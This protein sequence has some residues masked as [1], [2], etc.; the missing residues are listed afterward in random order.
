MRV[1]IVTVQQVNL[2]L[3]VMLNSSS[4]WW[5]LVSQTVLLQTTS[6]RLISCQCYLPIPFHFHLAL[7]SVVIPQSTS[8]EIPRQTG[9]LLMTLLH[10]FISLIPVPLLTTIFSKKHQSYPIWLLGHNYQ[11]MIVVFPLHSLLFGIQYVSNKPLYTW[12]LT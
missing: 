1:M 11:F 6:P 12:L 5:S 7:L 4:L 2:A 10:N 8:L 3:M 9:I